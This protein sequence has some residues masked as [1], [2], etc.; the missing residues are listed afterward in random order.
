MLIAGITGGFGTGKSFAAAI[1]K[2]LGAEVID[3]DKM[4]HKALRKGS[5]TYKKIID[6]FGRSILDGSGLISRKKLG[7]EVFSDKRKVARLNRIIHPIVIVQIK[8]RIS[9]FKG[10]ILVIDAPL[11]CETSLSGL[12]DALI[13]VTSSRE[14][15]IARCIKKFKIKKE[16][17]YK[18]TAC[19]MPLKTKINKADYVI[20][21][22][23]TRKETRMQVIK[24]WQDL[25]KG[26]RVWR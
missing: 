26:A 13:V 16:D 10:K 12:I 24:I 20:D 25:N 4:A 19:Q 9:S 6:V 17:V 21:N 23:G 5:E 3:A 11:I 18:R 22:N 14:K 8:K 1:F 2:E 15:Q 7:R